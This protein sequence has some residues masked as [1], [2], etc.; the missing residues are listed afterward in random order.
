MI[1]ELKTFNSIHLFLT[2]KLTICIYF[3]RRLEYKIVRL[4]QH[5]NN[6]NIEY[7]ETLI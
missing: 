1:F 5:C 4:P 3:A 2:K 6:G 7:F